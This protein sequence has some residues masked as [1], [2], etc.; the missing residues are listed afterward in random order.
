MSETSRRPARAARRAF[1][2]V[3]LLVVIAIIGVLLALLLPAVNAARE[4]SRR[5]AC[6]N[7]L[8]QIGLAVQ[9][10][11]SA[12][13]KFPPGKKYSGPRS[14]PQ[15]ESYSWAIVILPHIE[16]S[17]VSA[18]LDLKLPLTSPTNATVAGTVIPI[19]LCPSTAQVEE[20]RGNDGR[21]F[22]L[23]GHPGEGF[24]CIDYLGISGPDK[25]KDNPT[26]GELYGP[27]RGVLIGTK[28]LPKEDELI[29]PPA[30]T[31][32][33]I[34][35]GLSNTL[36]VVECSGRGADVNKSGEV[37]SLNGAWASGGNVSHIKMG[38]NEE[39]PPKV[40]EDERVFSDHTGGANAAA[41]D[42]SVHF[43]SND[44]DAGVLRTLCSRD[45]DEPV[46][47]LGG[48]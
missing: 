5:S 3:E 32:A 44:L 40:W 13:R 1:T 9:N 16:G 38:V 28:G 20:H 45:G 12:Y 18:Q 19:F 21:L 10:H 37:K 15:V 2:L 48:Q 46:E 24:A 29:E 14:D 8:K 6:Q 23:N 35:D 34:T 22:G 41:A 36:M 17:A 4:A 39:V 42:G 27:Q 31:P 26:T 47:G 43:L 7:N 11:L 33:S 25:D 30:I